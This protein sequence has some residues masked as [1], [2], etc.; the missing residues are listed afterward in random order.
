MAHNVFY[1]NNNNNNKSYNI[2]NTHTL[3][4]TVPLGNALPIQS[5]GTGPIPY[6]NIII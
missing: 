2:D 3:M 5:G 6:K 4:Y 1:N